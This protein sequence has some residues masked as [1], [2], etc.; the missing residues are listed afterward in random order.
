MEAPPERKAEA[1]AK[2]IEH[3]EKKRIITAGRVCALNDLRVNAN[4]DRHNLSAMLSELL[5]LKSVNP[6]TISFT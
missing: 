6:S 1:S 2:A 3:Y 5:L 4:L